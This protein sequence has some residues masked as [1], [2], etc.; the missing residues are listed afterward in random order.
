MRENFSDK[1]LYL[2]RNKDMIEAKIDYKAIGR[3]IRA[4]RKL[5]N[6]TQERLANEV[7]LAP[8]HVSN[9]ET[10]NTKLSLPSILKIAVALH[11]DVNSLLYDN[12]PKVEES[13]DADAKL[14]LSD[15]TEKERTVLLELLASS[16]AI[17]RKNKI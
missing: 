1:L 11:T 7:D 6:L 12:I 2:E 13:Y 14:I 8:N 9:I 17:L 10:G 4:A 15:C 5:L 16:K 3:R